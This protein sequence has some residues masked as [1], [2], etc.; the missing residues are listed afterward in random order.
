MTGC[1]GKMDDIKTII[2]QLRT[3]LQEGKSEDDIF[4]IL[5]PL[6][7]KNPET[8]SKMADLLATVPHPMMAGILHRM[9]E[10]SEDKK[11]RKTI[12]R[13]L[14]RLKSRGIPV[15]EVPM[16]KGGSI[17]H[18]LQA[19]PPKGFGSNYDFLGN[20]L[21]LLLIPHATRAWINMQGV[22][23]EAG[24]LLDFLGDE[25]TRKR[26]RSFRDD[27]EK[28]T[29]FPFVE[30]EAPYVGFLFTQAYQI[31]LEL[32]RSPLQSYLRLRGEIERIKKGYRKPLIYSLIPAEEVS[33]NP[34]F[35]SKAA[36]LLNSDILHDWSI[37][38]DLVRPYAEAVLEAQASKIVLSQ[39]QKETRFQEIYQRAVTELFPEGRKSQIQ[40]RL[41]EMAYY[42]IKVNKVE[43]AKISLAMAIDLEKPLNPFRPN[44]FLQ[45]L[46]VKSILALMAEEEEKK[47]G[48]PSFI[49]KP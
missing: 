18:P 39:I 24:E 2:D 10:M 17:L 36:D 7:G 8:D 21:L 27:R 5:H 15:G 22:V 32:G 40:R 4:Q 19:E 11:V 46:V 23:S 9:V 44:P 3:S 16:E 48:E 33:G 34:W 28:R 43:E 37:G 14:Y 30:M 42:F 41:E 29:P 20:R 49:V 13:S 31:R 47:T 25:T 26:F 38:E 35:L 12:K 1:G 45:Q 6:M